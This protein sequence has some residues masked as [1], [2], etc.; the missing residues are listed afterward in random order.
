MS[1]TTAWVIG[2]IKNLDYDLTVNASAQNVS[3]SRYLY[4]ASASL[5]ILGGIVSA[6]TAAGVAGASAVLTRDRRVKISAG[7]VFSIT[8]D[9]VGLR[10]L[11]GYTGNLAAA[12]SYTATNVSPLLWSPAHPLRPDLSPLGTVG[13]RRPLAYYTMSPTNGSTFV[14]SHGSR[15]EQRY[16]AA[17]VATERVYPED[18]AG[19][20]WVAWFDQCGAKGYSFYVFPEVIEDEGSATTAT[21]TGGLGPY[22]LLPSGRA[23]SWDYVRS[24][25]LEM[26]ESHAAVSFACR[27]VPE[28]T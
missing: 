12:A 14:V 18:E 3:G 9:D 8:W 19:G 26:V 4:H 22:V 7:G 27:V 23:P 25:G 10:N 1:Y 15:V 11:L 17:Y 6:M 20:S 16:S 5:S 21:L 2:S 13:I 24:R 28:Y